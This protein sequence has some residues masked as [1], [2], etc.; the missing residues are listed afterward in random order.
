LVHASAWL[1][2]GPSQ[3]IRDSSCEHRVEVGSQSMEAVGGVDAG[4]RRQSWLRAATG[5]AGAG[6]GQ[7]WSR[8][9]AAE[10]GGSGDLA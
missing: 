1:K 8:E 9:A 10:S 6:L 4:T 5:S 3:G 7:W 2:R